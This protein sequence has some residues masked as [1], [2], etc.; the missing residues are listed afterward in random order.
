MDLPKLDSNEETIVDSPPVVS[1]SVDVG[2]SVF[3]NC[4]PANWNISEIEDGIVSAVNNVSGETFQ[5]NLSDF[6]KAL[7]G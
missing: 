1:S 2:T 7:R 5:G 4:V 6:N 3:E